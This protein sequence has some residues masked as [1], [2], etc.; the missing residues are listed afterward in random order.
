[1]RNRGQIKGDAIREDQRAN[2]CLNTLPWKRYMQELKQQEEELR[3]FVKIE[4]K[5]RQVEPG[6]L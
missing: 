1:M 3:N 6:R 4:E 2:T 5:A